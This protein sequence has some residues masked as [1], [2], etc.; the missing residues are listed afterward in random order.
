MGKLLFQGHGS[1]RITTNDGVVIYVDPFL[2]DGYDVEADIILVTHEHHDHN[3]VELPKKKE[4]TIIIRQNNL[5]NGTIYNKTSLLGV[6]IEAVQAYNKNHDVSNCVG[7]ILRFDGISLY[8]SGD[9][10]LTD[11]M[12]NKLP[13][14]NI[15]YALLPIDGIYNMD[16]KEAIICA[17]YIKAKHTIPIHMKPMELF[18]MESALKFVHDSRLII[19]AGEEINL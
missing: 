10:S 9:T 15:D 13:S 4:S 17:D 12:K 2:G 19:K 3:K 16:V 11:D 18:D 6:E 8:A 14:Y 1:Y 7:Y 5:K